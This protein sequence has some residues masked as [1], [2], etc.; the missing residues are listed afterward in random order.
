MGDKVDKDE[1]STTKSGSSAIP[2]PEKSTDTV[3]E[4]PAA[5]V[6]G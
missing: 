5:Q 1:Q 2:S 4:I 3:M 6:S